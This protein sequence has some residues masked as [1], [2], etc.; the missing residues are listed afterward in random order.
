MWFHNQFSGAVINLVNFARNRVS[1]RSPELSFRIR[2]ALAV[3]FSVILAGLVWVVSE[4]DP[5]WGFPLAAGLIGTASVLILKGVLSRLAL[6]M[7][8]IIWLS[9]GLLGSNYFIVLNEVFVTMGFVVG[10][11]RNRGVIK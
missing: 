8:S 11:V 3:A 10:L 7:C 4:L 6:L 9:Y 2:F 1:L 5:Y